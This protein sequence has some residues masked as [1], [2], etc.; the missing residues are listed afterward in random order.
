VTNARAYDI[1]NRYPAGGFAASGEDLLR[2]VI[3][4]GAGKVLGQEA[5]HE[6]WTAQPTADGTKGAFGI[7]WGVSQWK[8]RAH[9]GNEW[10]R[11]I[12]DYFP[13]L[14]SG[15]GHRSRCPVQC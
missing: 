2:F 12:H 13:S 8:G 5:L 15:L 3:K 14:L 6:M 4:V 9:G 7:G 1:S 10:S 11:T